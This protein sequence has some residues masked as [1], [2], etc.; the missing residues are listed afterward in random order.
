MARAN[1]IVLSSTHNW[2]DGMKFIA[3]ATIPDVLPLFQTKLGDARYRRKVISWEFNFWK[4]KGQSRFSCSVGFLV[5]WD[6][7]MTPDPTKDD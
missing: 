6:V 7:Y 1:F 5:G 2:V 3:R 4:G